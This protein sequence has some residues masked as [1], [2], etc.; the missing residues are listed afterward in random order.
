MA[1][2]VQRLCQTDQTNH[3]YLSMVISHQ[4]RLGSPEQRPKGFR[5]RSNECFKDIVSN[6]LGTVQESDQD[7]VRVADLFAMQERTLLVLLQPRRNLFDLVSHLVVALLPAL[8]GLYTV[9]GHPKHFLASA[10]EVLFAGWVQETVG[11]LVHSIGLDVCPDLPDD[12]LYLVSISR[13][14]VQW[15]FRMQSLETLGNILGFND[16]FAI[17]QLDGRTG[18]LR[19]RRQAA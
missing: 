13:G 4:P 18:G 15:L 12:L 2:A 14:E 16:K 11:N 6:S 1:F 10:K 19:S 9:Q 5:V 7:E 3:L 17:G 8:L